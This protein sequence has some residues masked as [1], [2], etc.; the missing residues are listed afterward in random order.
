MWIA[1]LN[2]TDFEN[3][4]L[5]DYVLNAQDGINRLLTTIAYSI[6]Y[7]GNQIDE[8]ELVI[9]N[10]PLQ[11]I[12]VM[13]A[14][15]DCLRISYDGINYVKFKDLDFVNDVLNNRMKTLTIYGKASVNVYNGVSSIQVSIKDY[16]LV[17]DD[18]KYDF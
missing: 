16:E 5:V 6:Q 13:G 10:L 15:K 3:C 1:K 11:N 14:N 12:L 8:I 2:A 18:H 9:K 4:Y 17:N 7:F